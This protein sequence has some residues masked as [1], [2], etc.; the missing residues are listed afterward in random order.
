MIYNLNKFERDYMK[1]GKL[2]IK[3]KDLE[4]MRMKVLEMKQVLEKVQIEASKIFFS[5]LFLKCGHM[6]DLRRSCKKLSKQH[7]CFW[8]N[9]VKQ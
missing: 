6:I 5:R 7:F 4:L 1:C 2:L 9:H 8:E 3:L